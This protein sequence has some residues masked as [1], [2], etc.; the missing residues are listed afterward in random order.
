MFVMITNK[1]SNIS[2]IGKIWNK[3]YTQE[4]SLKQLTLV[5]RELDI[6]RNWALPGAKPGLAFEAPLMAD[7][8][9][10]LAGRTRAGLDEVQCDG[11][12]REE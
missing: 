6:Y 7:T 12:L 2:F 4:L 11:N 5:M 9:E 1:H 3:Y 10:E 8:A